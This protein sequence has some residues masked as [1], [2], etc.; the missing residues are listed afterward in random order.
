MPDRQSPQ[1][2]TKNDVHCFWLGHFPRAFDGLNDAKICRVDG[3]R[4]IKYCVCCWL[5]TT[6][7]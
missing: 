6:E 7:I 3:L 2:H 5:A 4:D 1:A